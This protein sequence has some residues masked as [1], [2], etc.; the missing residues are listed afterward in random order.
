V[1]RVFERLGYEVVRIS[2]GHY[3]LEHSGR[4]SLQI[5]YHGGQTVKLGL[6]IAQIRR[7]GF[8]LEEFEAAL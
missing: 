5:P 3:I 7:A 6:L 8:T 1:I 2:G 4:P